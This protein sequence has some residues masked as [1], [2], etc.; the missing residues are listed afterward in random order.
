VVVRVGCTLPLAPCPID[1]IQGTISN[2]ASFT[3]WNVM[4]M[5]VV[6]YT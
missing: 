3:G 1:G 5:S 6:E 2:M 4:P